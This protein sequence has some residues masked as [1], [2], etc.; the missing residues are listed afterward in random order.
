[1]EEEKSNFK[2]EYDIKDKDSNEN[3]MK[4]KPSGVLT[5]FGQVSQNG[6]SDLSIQP[7]LKIDKAKTICDFGMAYGL[8]LLQ[9]FEECSH[10]TKAIG[11]EIHANRYKIA[12]DNL[13]SFG[14][15]LR[16]KRNIL[17]VDFKNTS[18]GIIMTS[19]SRKGRMRRIIMENGSVIEY[20][21]HIK[22][23]N[24][25]FLHIAFSSGLHKSLGKL[26]S[27]TKKKCTI[28]SYQSLML[29]DIAAEILTRVDHNIKLNTSWGHWRPEIYVR[30]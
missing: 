20:P 10:I 22:R 25:V 11:V 19:Q 12:V 18:T 7:V 4:N 29:N 30:I 17:Y 2:F 23:A 28:L 21:H 24:V 14:N 1:M 6:V 15:H 27:Q 16:K 3:I 8:L 26:I 13:H 9:L 5:T